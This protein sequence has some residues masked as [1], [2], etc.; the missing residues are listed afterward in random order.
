MHAPVRLAFIVSHPVQYY[1][2][3]YQRL[4]RRNDLAIRVF[5][6]W[7]GARAPAFDRGFGQSFAWD[8]PLMQGYDHEVVTN[9]ARDPGTHHFFGL[10][11][12]G[13][14]ASVLEWC[15]DAVHV[16]GYAGLS[17]LLAMRRL[18]DRGVPVLFRGDS[19]LLDD[20]RRGPGWQAKRLLLRQ[21]YSWA[22]V[23]LH[24]GTANKSYYEAF[25]VTAN[26][27]RYCPHSIDVARFA[28]PSETLER[29][30]QAWRRQ[31]EI[32]QDRMVLL[33]AGKFEP[34]KR[35]L[36]IMRAVQ[37][38]AP[39]NVLLLM[40][41]A[42]EL[43]RE[44]RRLAASDPARFRVLPFQNQSRMPLVY[45]LGEVFV[46]PSAY[47]E[48]WGLAVNEAMACAR[49]VIVSDKVGCAADLVDEQRG[50]VFPADDWS[51]LAR[52][53]VAAQ[54]G[55]ARAHMGAA[56]SAAAWSH[57]VAATEQA[58][59]AAVGELARHS[60]RRGGALSER[61]TAA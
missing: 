46:L 7:H 39:P 2:P 28:E 14:L 15:P 45:R 36:E 54:D 59:V 40:V 26:R 52:V 13:L 11:N 4:A 33:F 53:L 57:D 31:L 51:A 23:C 3:L 42:G 48:T 43:D 16:T 60:G 58:L 38:S 6:T 20:T 24:V 18:R 30:A 41:G 19:H 44:V 35:P 61:R 21:V 49:P 17:H 12:P 1:A 34:R 29:D 37:R 25:D 55:E 22:T 27:L 8:V 5:F 10:R 47:G 50:W 32:G 9:T 56:A